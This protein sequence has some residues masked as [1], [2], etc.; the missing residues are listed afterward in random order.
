VVEVTADGFGPA[1]VVTARPEVAIRSM[2]QQLFLD[3]P[4]SAD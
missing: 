3:V 1:E 4:C 2:S